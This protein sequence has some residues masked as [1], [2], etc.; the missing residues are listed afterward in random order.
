[1][2]RVPTLI[3]APRTPGRQIPELGLASRRGRPP[4]SNDRSESKARPV[5]LKTP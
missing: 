1:M 5:T 4:R 3:E 2:L